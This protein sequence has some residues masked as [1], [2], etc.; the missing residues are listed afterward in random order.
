MADTQAPQPVP[1]G[2]SAPGLRPPNT[3]PPEP[4]SRVIIRWATR[5]TVV[6]T[7]LSVIVHIVFLVVGWFVHVG[8]G[9]GGGRGGPDAPVEVAYMSGVELAALGETPLDT[10]TPAIDTGDTTDGIQV[11]IADAPGGAGLPDVGDLGAIGDGLGGAGTGLG[12]GVG[13]GAGGTGGSTAFFGVEAR[14]S[15]FVYIVDVSGSMEGAKLGT[16]KKELINSLEKLTD[17][18]HFVVYFFASETFSLFART[19]GARERWI[20]ATSKEKER[21]ERVIMDI[22]SGGGTVPAPAF[23]KAFTLSPKP[24]AIYFMTDGLF[25]AELA[26]RVV[27]MNREGRTIPIHCIAFGD[28]SSEGLMRR[29]ARES[30]GTYTFVEGPKK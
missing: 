18:S 3:V 23:V 1:G 21:A 26:D 20:N 2:A 19:D 8:G 12:I 25:D 29:I 10:T 22:A 6:G 28:R 15:R 11:D 16:L 24:D 30:E 17:G 5:A 4:L 7:T 27:R 13:S 14:G 9:Y